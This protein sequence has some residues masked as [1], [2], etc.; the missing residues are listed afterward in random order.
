MSAG[1]LVLVTGASGYLGAHCVKT[2]LE[3]G[4]RVRGT[5]RSLNN[6]KKVAP[7]KLL[8]P[9]GQNLSLVEADLNEKQGWPSAVAGC[10][11]VL[12]VASPFPLV[13][14]EET[15]KTAVA[16]TMNVLEA[17][18]E[19]ESVEKVVLTSS[20]A[21]I[22]EGHLHVDAPL[23]EDYWSKP[24]EA[25]AYP[26]SKTMAERA[27]WDFV[28]QKGHKNNFA[29]TVINPGFIIGPPITDDKGSSV[30]IVTQILSLPA[31]P[32]I[33]L[34]MID[35]RDCAAAH[36]AALTSTDS[37][38]QRVICCSED[39]AFMIDV[40]H[41]LRKEFGDQGY[42]PANY[43]IP[44]WI[45]RFGA[46]FNATMAG[47]APRLGRKIRFD[48]SRLRNVL[49]ITPRDPLKSVVEMVYEL[50]ERGHIKRTSKYR[51]KP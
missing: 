3:K 32:R 33:T 23:N 20:V 48:N 10:D 5:V 29:L 44:D 40:A 28:K 45:V 8:D 1:K 2:L 43:Q 34:S 11:F 15:I 13:G 46:H 16:G 38:G 6:E 31:L 27:A 14:T 51:G 4:Y 17:C 50:I 12:H 49:G 9:T 39:S 35:V 36:V 24:E 21:A 22:T 41:A 26:K 37:D 30:D 18:A 47:I 7:V 19:A 25:P 42:C